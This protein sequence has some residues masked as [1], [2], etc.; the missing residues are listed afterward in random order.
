MSSCRCPETPGAP[1]AIRCPASGS[2]GA[3]VDAL[4]VKALLTE[5][6]LRRC[7]PNED[8]FC[9][10]SNCEVVSGDVIERLRFIKQAKLDG[11]MLR[12]IRS[13]SRVT[14]KVA[15]P[16]RR[17]P[18]DQPDACGHNHAVRRSRQAAIVSLTFAPW[19]VLASILPSAHVHEADA[20]QS[21]AI[22]HRHL[23]THDHDGGEWTHGTGRIVW[24]D[25]VLIHPVKYTVVVSAA[26]NSSQLAPPS[27]RWTSTPVCDTAPPHGPPRRFKSLRAPPARLLV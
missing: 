1:S 3:M 17:R 23:D 15:E 11:L 20:H 16:A 22:A 9:P 25:D 6:A 12:E 4:T 2:V 13:G 26:T 21:N 19:L 27:P 10:D 18:V 14:A 7:N 8:R 24:L 5:I